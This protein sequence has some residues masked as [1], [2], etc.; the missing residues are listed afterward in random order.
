MAT[1]LLETDTVSSAASTLSSLASQITSLASSVNGY[2]TSNEDG[3]DF[4]SAKSVIAGNIEAC[5]TKVSNTSAVLNSVVSSHTSLQG[6]LKFGA[7]S[8]ADAA[9]DTT[10]TTTGDTT[11][12]T[13]TGDTTG[14]TTTGGTTGGYT[15]GYT[16]GGTTG[17]GTTGGGYVPTP[18]PTVT[19]PPTTAPTTPET[20]PSTV[21]PATIPAKEIKEKVTGIDHATVAT[22]SLD[23]AG[24]RIFS[25]KDLKYDTTGYAV[26]GG[27]LVIS[28]SSAF[29][30]VGDEVT[31]AMS[32]GSVLNCIIGQIDDS[33]KGT[34]KFFVNDKWKKDA[35]GNIPSDFVKNISK[36]YNYGTNNTYTLDE[37]RATALDWAVE[38]AS[39]NKI[40]YS[41]TDRWDG[42][43]YDA[44]SFV[45][46]AFEKAG[47]KVR[48]AG[49]DNVT[50]MKAAFEKLGFEWIPGTPDV[51][52]LQPGDIL[53]NTKSHTEI[54]YGNG[55]MVG[56]HGDTDGSQGDSSGGEISVSNYSNKN[57][58]GVLRYK[59]TTP[60][61]TPGTP[62]PTQSPVRPTDPPVTQPG[63][64]PVTQPGTPPVTQPQPPTEPT[65]PTQPQPPT[66]PTPPT[67]PQPPTAPETAGSTVPII[68]SGT[69]TEYTIRI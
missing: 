47:F 37:K 18:T 28:C 1:F 62:P 2:D 20:T 59:G 45:I 46:S 8:A 31:F 60:A 38:I 29:G 50:N 54:Y 55:L 3:F 67:Q 22:D 41:Q 5:S 17:G 23:E 19:D 9:A 7:A 57:W 34:V 44:S 42:K 27:M 26:I 65:P 58:E 15:G 32:D 63:T 13:T 30:K 24:K 66:E 16:G 33:A 40:G 21:A 69:P 49:A 35:Q 39:N 52:N 56:A 53:L 48:E 51:K 12:G 6:S 11:G 4:A 36:V 25:N 68:H 61:T 43:S 14:G 10:G 64:P